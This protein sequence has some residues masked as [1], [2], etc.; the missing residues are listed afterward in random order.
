MIKPTAASIPW[1]SLQESKGICPGFMQQAGILC[2]NLKEYALDSCNKPAPSAPTERYWMKRPIRETTHCLVPST[3]HLWND[4]ESGSTEQMNG[5]QG[6]RRDAGRGK[7]VRLSK[8]SLW[9]PIPGG[10]VLLIDSINVNASA[11][12]VNSSS[13]GCYSWGNLGKVC[14]GSLFYLLPL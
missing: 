1:S 13:T 3:A 10:N 6:L 11:V 8:S 9:D 4:Q 14:T 7:W 12:I 5:C 2:R